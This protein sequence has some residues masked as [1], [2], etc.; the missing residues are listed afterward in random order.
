[1]P[2]PSPSCWDQSLVVAGC[3]GLWTASRREGVRVLCLKQLETRRLIPVVSGPLDNVPNGC[4]D[5]PA[6]VGITG[7]SQGPGG[8]PSP[9]APAELGCLGGWSG[10]RPVGA[11][12]RAQQPFPVRGR[13][14]WSGAARGSGSGAR[15]AGGRRWRGDLS[16]IALAAKRGAAN[17]PSAAALGGGRGPRGREL[18]S[19]AWGG[20]P[21]SLFTGDEH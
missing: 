7:G 20:G 1:V 11:V 5:R 3:P 10:E 14:C 16:C 9:F 18:A 19:W 6:L 21:A 17:S 8:L 2:F 13:V 12:S 4:W 15:G